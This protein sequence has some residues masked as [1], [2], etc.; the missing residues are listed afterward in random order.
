M[1]SENHETI[2]Q[3]DHLI[4]RQGLCQFVNKIKDLIFENEL[5]ITLGVSYLLTNVLL[6]ETLDFIY[7]KLVKTNMKAHSSFYA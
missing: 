2:I 5:L 6:L 4:Y 3:R 7:S 1:A